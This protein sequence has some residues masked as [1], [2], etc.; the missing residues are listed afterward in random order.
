VCLLVVLSRVVR[1]AP[2]VV[3]A[4]RDERYSR[5]SQS[6][7]VLRAAAPRILGGRD[8]LAGGTWLAVNEHGVVAGLTNRPSPAGR[9][10]SKRSRGELPLA[11]AAH[12][13]ARAA[14]EDVASRLRP[15]DYN[16]CWLLVGDRASLY[17]MDMTA[18]AAPLVT[19][20]P[21]G[22]H[23]LENRPLGPPSAKVAHVLQLAGGAAGMDGAELASLLRALL[24]D[25]TVPAP[26]APAEARGPD[27][28]IQLGPPELAACCVHTPQYGTRS[29]ELVTV[30]SDPRALPVVEVADG[31]PCTA[32]FRDASGLWT[33]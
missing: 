13:D 8:G 6:I 2:L 33:G 1:G 11:L 5:P 12:R 18:T 30:P 17:S 19:E 14:V 3:A 25:H 23:V 24:A 15:G 22:I 9:D 16:P 27:A 31:P 29:A 26:D 32:P 10:P 28:P 21:A 4:N 7:A 20:L